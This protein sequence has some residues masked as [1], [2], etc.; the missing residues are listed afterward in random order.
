MNKFTKVFAFAML[1]MAGVA[2]AAGPV[3]IAV[4]HENGSFT[5]TN[6]NGAWA[7]EWTASA[8]NPGLKID[9]EYNNIQVAGSGDL[10]IYSGSQGGGFNLTFITDEGWRVSKYEVTLLT[11]TSDTYTID[12]HGKS[13]SL[14]SAAPLTISEE[15]TATET[16]TISQHGPNTAVTYK[17]FKVTLVE[18]TEAE[19][20][21]PR[22]EVDAEPAGDKIGDLVQT[23]VVGD[24][25]NQFTTWYHLLDGKSFLTGTALTDAGEEITNV[26]NDEYLYCVV[27]GTLYN[28]AGGVATPVSGAVVNASGVTASG[29]AVEAR[30]AQKFCPVKPELGTTKRSNDGNATNMWRDTWTSDYE[31]TVLLSGNSRNMTTTASSNSIVHSGDFRLETGNANGGD[32]TWNFGAEGANYIA[33]YT[34]L[35][36]KHGTYTD[37]TTITPNG[38]AATALASYYKRI[39]GKEYNGET[40]MAYFVQNGK[41]LQGAELTDIYVTVRRSC[42]RVN[43]REGYVIYPRTNVERRIPAIARVFEGEHAGRLVTIYDYRHNGGDI[44][45]GNISLQISVSDDNGATWSEP[46]YL[47]DAD[48]NPVTTFPAELDKNTGKWT[49]FQADN[50][51]YWNAAFGDAAIVADRES[52]KLLLMAVGGTVNFF[53]GRRAN[54]N[55]CVRWTSDDGGETWTP[56]T[57]VTE[58]ILKLFDGEPAFGY[59]DSQF[60]GSG[61]IMQSRYVKVGDYYR[62]YCVLSSQNGGNNSNT[63]NWVLYSDDFGQ[64]WNVLGGTDEAPVGTTGDECKAEELPD[65]SVFIAGRNKNG[66]RNF[67]IFRYTNVTK[68]EGKWTGRVLTDMGFGFINACDG[69]IMVLPAVCNDDNTDC[70]LVL[71]SFPYGGGRNFVSIAYQGIKDGA[72]MKDANMFTTWEGRYRIS[73]GQSVYSTMAWQANDKLAFFWENK[74]TNGTYLDLSIEEITDG[75]YSYKPDAQNKTALRLTRDLME[76]RLKEDFKALEGNRVGQ[77][78]PGS[79]DAIARVGAEYLASPSYNTYVKFN[80]L[81][82]DGATVPVVENGGYT[83]VSAHEGTYPSFTEPLYL[84]TDGTKL[85]ANATD[86]ESNVFTIEPTE[87]GNY[88]LHNKTANV[89]AGNLAEAPETDVPVSADKSQAGEYRFVLNGQ[90]HVAISN[91]NPGNA[92]RPA[93]HLASSQRIVPWTN[94]APASQWYMELIDEPEGY[95]APTFEEPEYDDYE[96]NYEHNCPQS[97]VVFD[98]IREVAAS[99]GE[100]A[101]F[102]LQGRR[103]SAPVRGQ[104]YITNT[105]RKIKF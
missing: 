94:D 82:Y 61:R 50:N 68:A 35:S 89:Y 71:Q 64:N 52:G 44:G 36:K 83:F 17:D 74:E 103:I 104:L 38:G 40:R 1:L 5:K 2:Q 58:D 4:T 45:G 22:L 43:E 92:S 18:V 69:E 15:F 93:V 32:F 10:V 62:V 16:P 13:A 101:Y 72:K 42:V 67:N 78:L 11:T 24:R 25:F 29:K 63:R 96:F 99:N 81:V 55:Q 9:V 41:N 97:E 60:I 85:I 20:D 105:G 65:G 51:K 3:E 28:K 84:D 47:K 59:I 39:E 33:D 87:S 90:S 26:Y 27:G 8:T 80:K 102:D 95:V 31:P 91:V 100:E 19:L 86:T 53:N 79:A 75:H 23:N 34:F 56:A 57:N 49:E 48:G 66:N 7:Q 46:A 54:P 14:T 21:A 70:Y 88:L 12:Y 73:D 30:F 37:A 76:E 6:G 98:G 77:L